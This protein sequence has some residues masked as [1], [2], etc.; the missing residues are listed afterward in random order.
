MVLAQPAQAARTQL[1]VFGAWAA[2]RDTRPTLTCYV[3][4]EIPNSL[5][6]KRRGP[7]YLSVAIAPRRGIEAQIHWAAGFPIADEH[8]VS[9]TAGDRRF[10]LLPRGESAWR[11]TLQPTRRSS[12]ACAACA[13]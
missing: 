4:A 10:T 9:L 13:A 12:T 8:P 6:G 2:L 5:S 7:N 3:I 11:R 1:G